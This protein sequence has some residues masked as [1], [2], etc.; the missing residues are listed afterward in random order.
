M[1]SV[2]TSTKALFNIASFLDKFFPGTKKWLVC[3][4]SFARYHYFY[5][6][7]EEE[8]WWELKVIP[9]I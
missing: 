5:V 3:K 6:A 9:V 4:H 2:L 7:V 8:G 1:F